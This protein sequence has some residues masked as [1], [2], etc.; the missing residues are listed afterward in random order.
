MRAPLDH[1]PSRGRDM[2]HRLPHPPVL[3][4]VLYDFA[5]TIYSMSILT[6]YFAVWLVVDLGRPDIAYSIAF[7]LS[8]ALVALSMPFMGALSDFGRLRRR[9]LIV[10]TLISVGATALMGLFAP[11]ARSTAGL[12]L[13]LALFGLSNYGFQGAQVFYNAILPELAP[14]R[15]LGRISGYGVAAGYAGAFIGILLVGPFVEGAVPGLGLRIPGVRA[16][17]RASA[18]LPTAIFFLLF[19]L[20]LLLRYRPPGPS[21]GD[22]SRGPSLPGW[23]AIAADVR[24]SLLDTRRYPGVRSFLLANLFFVDAVHTVIVF[25]ALYAEKVMG[26]PDSVKIPFFLVATV[27]AGLGSLVAGRLVDRMGPLRT[28]RWVMAG[29][30]VCLALLT[31]SPNQAAFWLA[32]CLMGALLGCV[33]TTSRPL[34]AVLTPRGEHGRFFGLFALSNKAAAILGPLL[35]GTVVS[36]FEGL[37]PF[38]YRLATSSLVLLILMGF[39]FL[40]GVSEPSSAPGEAPG[41]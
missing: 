6:L 8:M 29:W 21:S 30:I 1:P 3:S 39:F 27:A 41:A 11:A 32:G 10:Y 15:R 38:R 16:G 17:G 35:W 4:W 31:A 26:F 22:S 40:R 24:R 25:A 34:L 37:G 20:P 14:R 13:V 12:L 9:F 33:W 36:L 19:A 18:F 23:R 5:N 7:S 2:N 28:L